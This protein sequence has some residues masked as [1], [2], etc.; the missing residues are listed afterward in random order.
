MLAFILLVLSV[1]LF[2]NK[3]YASSVAWQAFACTLL[4]HGEP[5]AFEV[6]PA[7]QSPRRHMVSTDRTQSTGFKVESVDNTGFTVL[8]EPEIP[9]EPIAE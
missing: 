9:V 4:G 2:A 3:F 8:Y 1:T 5:A 7:F 6:V